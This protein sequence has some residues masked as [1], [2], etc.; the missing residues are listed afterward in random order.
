MSYDT[1]LVVL[2]SDEWAIQVTVYAAGTYQAIYIGGKK[3]PGRR[4]YN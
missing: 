4:E 1:S 2:R 3:T